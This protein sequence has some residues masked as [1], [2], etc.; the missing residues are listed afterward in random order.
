VPAV[1]RTDLDALQFDLPDGAGQAVVHRLAFRALT[2]GSPG[3]DDCLAF[4]ECKCRAF[5][6]AAFV[7]IMRDGLPKGARFHLTSRD[8]A[9]ALTEAPR[10]IDTTRL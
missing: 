10:L 4:F 7:K 6:A 2:S 9:R 8:I 3:P 1:W 5:E